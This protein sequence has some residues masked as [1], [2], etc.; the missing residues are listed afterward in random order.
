MADHH[1]LL[2]LTSLVTWLILSIATLTDTIAREITVGRARITNGHRER[3]WHIALKAYWSPFLRLHRYII[4]RVLGWTT[5]LRINI[6]AENRE[7]ASLTR[8]HPVVC[9]ATKL[10]HRLRQSEYQANILVIAICSEVI[11]VTLVER[12][13]FNAKSGILFADVFTHRILDGIDKI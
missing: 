10:T 9:L 11:L 12:L 8:P 13:D 1:I 5:C 3:T 7:I 4:L 6:D 2:Y